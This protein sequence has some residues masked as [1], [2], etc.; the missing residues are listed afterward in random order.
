MDLFQLGDFV[1]HSGEKS[2]WKIDCD[3][4]SDGDLQTLAR[5]ITQLV[6]PINNVVGVPMGGL[7][8]ARFMAPLRSKESS[9]LLI[10]D[11]VLTTGKSMEKERELRSEPEVVGA[12]IFAR[13]KCPS[14]VKAVF[15]LA[16]QLE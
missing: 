14:W 16:E 13:G 1:L 8:L 7:R 9:K 12:V 10:V 4:L 11:D 3:C 2:K 5:L 15:Q 6:G